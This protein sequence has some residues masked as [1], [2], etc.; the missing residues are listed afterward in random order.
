MVQLD[1]PETGNIIEASDHR[2]RMSF[3]LSN[4]ISSFLDG[5][6]STNQENLKL[7][8]F[9]SD[10]AT[11]LEN[12]K[13]NSGTDL[14]ECIDTSYYY[15]IITAT[16]S[17]L[18]A[19]GN[20]AVS[21]LN[22]GRWIVYATAGTTEVARAEVLEYLFKPSTF[23]NATT[24]RII[25]S[26]TSPTAIQS[27]DSRD[28]GRRFHWAYASTGSGGAAGFNYTGTFADTATNTSCSSWSRVSSGGI[29]ST[30]TI[31]GSDK[32]TASG[33][34]VDEFG[35]DLSA[36]Q[37]DN[38]ATCNLSTARSAI[39]G[40][41]VEAL[42]ECVGDIV[43]SGSAGTTSYNYDFLTTGS[44]PVMTAT[45]ESDLTCSITTDST[46][47]TTSETIAIVKSIHTLTVGNTLAYEVSFDDGSNWLSA[48]ESVLTKVTNTGTSFRVR[49]TITRATNDETDSIT[50]YG[51]YY[52]QELKLNAEAKERKE[53]DN[54]K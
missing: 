24:A 40:S 28:I 54:N 18:S 5:A 23:G 44:I 52:S 50:S 20:V 17:A 35:L 43:W 27:S 30:W 46:T 4:Q 16:A 36:D 1:Y 53:D 39:A 34:T 41:E 11:S 49:M 51:A 37:E 19:S 29:T 9:V 3:M 12:M 22:D 38:P 7:D 8:L 42:I 33:G 15:L 48:T 45:T 2:M 31:G 26:L 6:T 14:Y 25:A 47:I 32:N 21:D 13:Y 10:T